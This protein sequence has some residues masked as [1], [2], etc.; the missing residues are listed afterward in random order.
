M[1][2]Q[3]PWLRF[4]GAAEFTV[5]EQV[6][7]QPWLVEPVV[8]QADPGAVADEARGPVRRDKVAAGNLALTARGYLSGRNRDMVCVLLDCHD[9][10]T[11]V[12]VDRPV[13][14][15]PGSQELLEGGLVEQVVRVPAL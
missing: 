1:P 4:V 12:Q 11:Q 13:A 2:W 9:L 5:A 15:Q 10:D 14:V 7:H 8:Q 3:S 6:D